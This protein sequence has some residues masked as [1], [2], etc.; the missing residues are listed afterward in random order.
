[1]S[2]R[3]GRRSSPI[4]PHNLSNTLFSSSDT[5][6]FLFLWSTFHAQ[7]LDF[8][9]AS[10]FITVHSFI[11]YLYVL[12]V[13]YLL[14]SRIFPSLIYPPYSYRYFFLFISHV[15]PIY[16]PP[17]YFR[18]TRIH[19]HFCSSLFFLQVAA[20]LIKPGN[21]N[22]MVTAAVKKVSREVKHSYR[23]KMKSK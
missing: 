21:T 5:S 9:V 17:P 3:H 11:L 4:T 13:T 23:M 6:V 18:N 19:Y 10:V 1:M 14:Q 2:Q 7:H 12:R 20:R 8:I 15:I 22:A 16:S